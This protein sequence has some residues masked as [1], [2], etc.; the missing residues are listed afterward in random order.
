MR[1][2]LILIFTL[3]SI[4]SFGQD[5]IV[6]HKLFIGLNF[7]PDY[8]YRS[9]TKN[10]Q[11]I[12]ESSWNRAKNLEDSIE[13][14]KFGFTTGI[15]FYY[16][17]N[18]RFSIESGIFYSLRG[19]KT[20]PLPILIITSSGNIDFS[21]K[22]S[23]I[24]NYSYLDFPL[25]VN[26]TFF[27]NRVRM[28][29]GLGAT[30]NVLLKARFSSDPPEILESAFA[31]T[32]GHGKYTGNKINISPTVSIGLQYELNEKMNLRIVPTFRYGLLGLDDKSYKTIHLWNAGINVGYCY[33]IK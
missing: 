10:D 18:E 31:L 15:N 16:F 23:L 5:T 26:Y 21:E 29:V 6:Q 28:I 13:K 7:S 27:K 2:I 17:I 9:L 11:S 8:C 30:L 14:P 33:R 25:K 1:R 24:S 3:F 22:A 19:Y 12:S 20:I 32:D 4:I